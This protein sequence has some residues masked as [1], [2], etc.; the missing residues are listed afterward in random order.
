MLY[1]ITNRE[2]IDEGTP[3]ER[4]RE[5]GKEAAQD[6]LRYG[7]YDIA[8]GEFTLYPEP[9]SKKELL[10]EEINDADLSSLKGSA[11]FFASLYRELWSS[12]GEDSVLFFV[13]GFNT[14]LDGVR[15]NFKD[16]HDRY[17]SDNTCSVK[18]I[19][20]FTWPGRSPVIPLHYRNDAK[21]A[22]RSGEALSRAID[23]LREFYKCFIGFSGN[24]PCKSKIHLMLHSMAH[25]VFRAAIR[26]SLDGRK[27][28][29]MPFDQILCMAGDV[30]YTIFEDN[31]EFSH[32]LD[33]GERVH[34]YFHKRDR[35]LDIS[36]YTK[37][38]TNMLGR[39]GRKRVPIDDP[40]IVDCDVTDT[41]DDP[42]VSLRDNGFNHWYYYTSTEVV[43][44]V[45]NVFNGHQSKY[46][47]YPSDQIKR[48]NQ[49]PPI[50]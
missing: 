17:V 11:R 43:K 42:G 8:N 33:Y 22:E 41:D 12:N 39:F 3:Q 31:R 34:I 32:L 6:N 13:H 4:I 35:V 19:V 2:I 25:R 26:A 27:T 37:N 44:D 7:S 14:D 23:S 38:F 5:D 48:M 21:D 15:E 36:K 10:Y 28:G 18:H 24:E 40:W 30:P 47:V 49:N 29:L 16:L 50:V 1:F 45:I 9:E 20:L 46:A